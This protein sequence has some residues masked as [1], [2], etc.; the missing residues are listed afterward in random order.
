M[1]MY[2]IKDTFIISMTAWML[3]SVR[4]LIEIAKLSLN[5]WWMEIIAISYCAGFGSPT[6]KIIMM[7][8]CNYRTIHFATH[9]A[10]TQ[11]LASI[12]SVK[13]PACVYMATFQ[14][15]CSLTYNNLSLIVAN[16]SPPPSWPNI[17]TGQF[18]LHLILPLCGSLECALVI[19]INKL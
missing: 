14:S 6:H 11:S 1:I 3:P 2:I 18:L 7:R 10:A 17:V 19:I 12:K 16:R 13:V 15:I 4:Y 5:E 8:S 9:P